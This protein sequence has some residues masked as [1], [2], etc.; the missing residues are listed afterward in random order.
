MQVIDNQHLKYSDDECT[1][2]MFEKELAS[3][4]YKRIYVASEC[5]PDFAII[6]G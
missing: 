6:K 5:K 2:E 3:S 1:K 4:N